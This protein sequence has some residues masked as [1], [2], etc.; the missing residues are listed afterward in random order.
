MS[1]SVDTL[2]AL[3]YE[4]ETAAVWVAYNELVGTPRCDSKGLKHCCLSAAS[5]PEDL[6]LVYL[7][8]CDVVG[9]RPDKVRL[10]SDAEELSIEVVRLPPGRL[11][12]STWA[13]A[14]DKSHR[15]HGTA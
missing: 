11:V 1:R 12:E 8:V 9:G 10:F 4:A 6:N 3:G 14:E 5:L 13:E 2:L 7:E 15:K